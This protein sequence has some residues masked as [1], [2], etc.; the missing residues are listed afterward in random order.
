MILCTE[1]IDTWHVR[2]YL[3]SVRAV[4]D[5]TPDAGSVSDPSTQYLEQSDYYAFGGRIDDGNQA[6]DQTNRYRYNGKEQLRFEGINLDPGLTDYG[7][8]YYAPTFGRWTSPDPL[9]DKYYSVS[10]YAFCNNN[11]VNFIDPDGRACGDPV[12]NPNIRGNRA[13]NL[14]GAGIRRT[15]GG[16]L[17]NHQGF[18]YYAPVGTEVLSV[19]DGTVIESEKM[20]KDYGQS[21]TIA[22]TD[23]DGN[24]IYTFYAHL[25]EIDV[26]VGDEVIEGQVIGKT[27]VSGNAKN[28]KG[29]NQHLHFELRTQKENAIGLT[30]KKDPNEIVDTKFYSRDPDVKPQ[31]DIGIIK[32]SKDGKEEIMDT[33]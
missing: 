15:E 8:R 33:Y 9:A 26:N 22:H 29:K 3:G 7:A 18:D 2:D 4:Y 24:E 5:I 27:G 30:G 12:R 32:V 16:G 13:S 23:S 6:F 1:F 28:L 21:I 14:Y 25:S 19:K 10:P 11:P 20:H 17:R 31:T